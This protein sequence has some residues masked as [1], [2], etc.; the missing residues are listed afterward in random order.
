VLERDAFVLDQTTSRSI[1]ALV[2]TSGGYSRVSYALITQMI[3][4]ALS[5]WSVHGTP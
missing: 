4:H 2:L 1:P 3:E 5:R